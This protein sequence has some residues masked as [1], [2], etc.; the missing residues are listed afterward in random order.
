MSTCLVTSVIVAKLVK[1]AV[2]EGQ[3][4]NLCLYKINRAFLSLGQRTD[5]LCLSRWH[6]LE[7]YGLVW[8][9]QARILLKIFQHLTDTKKSRFQH[10][11]HH[12]D[13][14]QTERG[15][16]TQKACVKYKVIKST[17]TDS[18]DHPRVQAAVKWPVQ[19]LPSFPY[20]TWPDTRCPCPG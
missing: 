3:S 14:T 13:S 16:R 8:T 6:A 12:H 15:S 9:K 7:N 4:I 11:K 18:P 10:C 20:Q 2:R 1:G 19:T 17:T 5:K